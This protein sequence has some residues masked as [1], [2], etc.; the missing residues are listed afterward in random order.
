MRVF[1]IRWRIVVTLIVL[2]LITAGGLSLAV[3]ALLEKSLRVGINEPMRAALTD[4]VDLAKEGY[5]ARKRILLLHAERLA[6]APL[7]HRIAVTGQGTFVSPL[8]GRPDFSSVEIF[9]AQGRRI[10]RQSEMDLPDASADDVRRNLR[11]GESGVFRRGTHALQAIAAIWDGAQIIGVLALS[12]WL[13]PEYVDR[14]DEISQAAQTYRHLRIMRHPLA[15]GY[16]YAFLVIAVV[17][18]AAAVG[19]GVRIAFGITDPLKAL[20]RGTEELAKDHLD[21]RIPKVR[22]DEIG[23][24]VDSFNRMA[25]DLK[26]NRARRIEAEKQAAWREIARR[27]AHEIKNPLTPIQL[28]VQQMRDAYWGDDEAY[29]K[30]LDDCSQIISE[31]MERLRTLVREFAEFARIP[32]LVLAPSNINDLIVE[33]VQ[34]YPNV[35]IELDLD[36]GIPDLDLDAEQMRR[37]LINLVVNAMDATK[38]GGQVAVMSRLDG[39]CVGVTVCDTGEGIEEAHLGRIFEPYFSTKKSGMGLGLAIV[40]RIVEEHRGRVE[41]KSKIEEG[42]V[43]KVILPQRPNR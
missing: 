40:K 38:E 25:Q 31:E 34:L 5:D 28:T 33:V 17:V 15:K 22:D 12:E 16:L 4:A 30:L 1:S 2:C 14:L 21:Y 29:R 39:E 32:E 20:V 24:L 26:E 6:A 19:T 36:R 23:A 37:V 7:V 10:W 3:R 41:V 42:T 43:F 9:D 18:V 13:E 11:S 8:L 35:Q 27:L